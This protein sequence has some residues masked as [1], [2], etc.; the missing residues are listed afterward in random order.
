MPR[1]LPTAI[2]FTA[3]GLCLSAC[4]TPTAVAVPPESSAPLVDLLCQQQQPCQIQ[5]IHDAGRDPQGHALQVVEVGLHGQADGGY[6]RPLWDEDHPD[7]A[8]CYTNVY[9][10]VTHSDPPQATR[11]LELCNDGYGASGIG[12]DFLE[13]SPNRLRHTQVGGSA[14]RWVNVTEWELAPLRVVAF[15]TSAYTTWNPDASTDLAWS[16]ESFAG[17]GSRNLPPCLEGGQ[18]ADGPIHSF[19]HSLI[20]QLPALP[21]GADWRQ[22]ALGRCAAHVDSSGNSGFVTHGSPGAADD[23]T[24][25]VLR[26]GPRTLLAEISDD[27]ISRGAAKWLHDDHL[28]LWLAP[29]DAMLY[30]DCFPPKATGLYQWGIM[31]DGQVHTAHG[32]APFTPTVEVHQID[33]QRYRLR[34]EVPSDFDAL[35]LVYSDS[36]D[37][38]RQKRLI[39][40]SAVDFGEAYSLGTVFSITDDSPVSCAVVD[41]ALVPTWR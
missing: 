5:R 15:S 35:S 21:G 31:L 23:A 14:H 22:V 17:F 41:G 10:R 27:H 6:A 36:D 39:A 24:L 19:R 34:I 33:A 38:Q 2:L 7:Q 30:A 13:V 1:A 29:K 4:F 11:I 25:S 28:E 26:V 9:W 37:G 8:E 20:P 16:W 40:T 32:K 12:E 18:P 3:L